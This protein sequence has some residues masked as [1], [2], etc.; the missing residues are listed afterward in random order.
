MTFADSVEIGYVLLRCKCWVVVITLSLLFPLF[1]VE[2]CQGV[3]C[4]QQ[5]SGV[6]CVAQKGS[7]QGYHCHTAAAG[8]PQKTCLYCLS[9]KAVQ[10]RF[11]LCQLLQAL[12][13]ILSSASILNQLCTCIVLAS[14]R[15]GIESSQ[16][17][18]VCL[19]GGY[20]CRIM[21]HQVHCSLFDSMFVTCN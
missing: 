13:W 18:V 4:C 19:C 6:M 12:A 14:N 1:L 20:A 8:E 11:L 21:M 9:L 5:H 7:K 10:A 2:P 17:K 15:Q 3:R 16:C